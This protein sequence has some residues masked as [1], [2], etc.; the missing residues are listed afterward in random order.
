M[1]LLLLQVEPE[2]NVT[3]KNSEV[4][5]SIADTGLN[6]LCVVESVLSSTT[7]IWKISQQRRHATGHVKFQ[8]WHM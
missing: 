5:I 4:L 3:E 2:V 6:Q 8:I 7:L 1:P